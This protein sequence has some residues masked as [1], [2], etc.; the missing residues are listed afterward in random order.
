MDSKTVLGTTLLVCLFLISLP[1]ESHYSKQFQMWA[2]N[3]AAR[4][5]AGL[6]LIA[7]STVDPIL[8][9]LGFLILF[10]WIADIQLLSSIKL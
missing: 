10:L 9:G 5:G 8:G 1:F 3:P 2:H 7:L 4:F 6:G